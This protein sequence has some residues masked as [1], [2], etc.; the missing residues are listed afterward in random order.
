M[1][2]EPLSNCRVRAKAQTNSVPLN[3]P[4]RGT[5]SQAAPCQSNRTPW[6][7][8]SAAPTSR[9]SCWRRSSCPGVM[10]W[11]DR[12]QV[13]TASHP[14]WLKWSVP[15]SNSN[16]KRQLEDRIGL[17]P[18]LLSHSQQPSGSRSLPTS[19]QK[20][21]RRI[22]SLVSSTGAPTCHQMRNKEQDFS[23]RETH[24]IQVMAQLLTSSAHNCNKL[25]FQ[26]TAHD[27]LNKP[28]ALLLFL[29]RPVLLKDKN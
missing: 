10:L 9:T 15:N 11:A 22:P 5:P 7:S 8:W 29:E 20:P 19:T 18:P 21:F 16:S 13:G 1:N 12:M 26:L 2:R 28:L 4:S 6:S 3:C 24:Q 25:W 14:P 17:D 23:H 27:L